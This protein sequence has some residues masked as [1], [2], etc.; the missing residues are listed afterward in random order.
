MEGRREGED[1][2]E[3]HQD[4]ASGLTHQRGD[5]EEAQTQCIE[6]SG[7]QAWGMRREVSAEGMHEHVGRAVEQQTERVGR[8]AAA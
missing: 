3:G 2:R 1:L 5:L 6:L 4:P 8:E 7:G